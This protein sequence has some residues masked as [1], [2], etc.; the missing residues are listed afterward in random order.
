[1]RLRSILL[2]AVLAVTIAT[3]ARAQDF[4]EVPQVPT[5]R[6]QVLV[7][8]DVVRI[9]DL[10]DNAGAFSEIAIFRSRSRMLKMAVLAPIPKARQRTATHRVGAKPKP[11]IATPQTAIAPRTT[12]PCRSTRVTHPDVRPMTNEPIEM[13]ANS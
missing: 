13:P 10:V 11:M 4:D 1:M 6:P 2:A 3:P 9:G 5:L 12:A 7:S 8:G